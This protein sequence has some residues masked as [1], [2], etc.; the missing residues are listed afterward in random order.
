MTETNELLW[1][2]ARNGSEKAFAEIVRGH[3][4]FV[5]STAL[6]KV[7]GDAHLAEDVT[8]TVFADLARKAK[9]MGKDVVLIG[10]LHRDTCF[11]AADVVRKER[12]RRAREQKAAE[13][14]M[15]DKAGEDVWARV[16]PVV[17]DA[18]EKLS[19]AERNAL[20]LRFIEGKSWRE[21]GHALAVSEDAVQ[22]RAGRA[23]EKLRAILARRG[24]I[25]S[26]AAIGGLLAGNSV[27]AAPAGLAASLVGPALAGASSVTTSLAEAL[28]MTTKTKVAVVAVA[29]IAAVTTPLVWQ[30]Q[31]NARLRGEL[32]VAREENGRLAG[33]Q[34]RLASTRANN[35]APNAVLNWQALESQDYRQYI[36]NLR[37]V[38]CPE[39]TIRDIIITDLDRTYGKRIASIWGPAPASY[40]KA[41][42]YLDG[43]KQHLE[44][45]KIEEE[46][47]AAIRELLGIDPDEESGRRTGSRVA[48]AE[49]LE[50]L[51]AEQRSRL[52]EIDRQAQAKIESLKLIQAGEFSPEYRARQNEAYV[53]KDEQIKQLLSPEQLKEYEMRTSRH[54]SMLGHGLRYFNPTEE[55]FRTIY[56]LEKQFGIDQSYGGGKAP[57]PAKARQFEE[58][59]K[60]TLGERRY[61]DYELTKD[62]S[63]VIL[64]EIARFHELPQEAARAVYDMNKVAEQQA[65]ALRQDGSMDGPGRERALQA[66]RKQTEAEAAKLLGE[67]AF[68]QYRFHFGEWLKRKIGPQPNDSD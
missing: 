50:F 22:K 41:H 9:S 23:L 46:K 47:R 18:M 42:D 48:Y 4:D 24:V 67:Q 16:A 35:V 34:T 20:L 26:T 13:M 56:E 3:V 60:Q 66:L 54:A 12:R 6:R 68:Q 58:I 49:G 40:W 11:R 21:T 32:M 53:W 55:E 63:Y 44:G 59:L 14:H 5:Y 61:A 28:F 19:D 51:S 62:S 39:Q 8:Q 2:Y 30:Q 52:R 36:A 29:G 1:D 7:G 25:V 57:D 37:A 27:Q 43:V 31:A 45:R 33:E 64:H 15:L 38:G 17:D 65:K 10:W